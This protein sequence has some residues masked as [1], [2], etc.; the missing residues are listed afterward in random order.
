VQEAE[1]EAA[2]KPKFLKKTVRGFAEGEGPRAVHEPVHYNQK[3][4]RFIEDSLYVCADNP[5]QFPH[6]VESYFQENL[7]RRFQMIKYLK[8]EIRR[9]QIKNDVKRRLLQDQK[10]KND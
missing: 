3:F 5:P 9:E 4:S 7:L 8:A 6:L 2:I 10:T 1:A